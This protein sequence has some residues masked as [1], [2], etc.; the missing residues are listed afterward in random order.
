MKRKIISLV[1]AAV[2]ALTFC[3]CSGGAGTGETQESPNGIYWQA[4]VRTVIPSQSADNTTFYRYDAEKKTINVSTDKGFAEDKTT[5]SS[6]ETQD[7]RISKISGD[8]GRSEVTYSYSDGVLT[9]TCS[10][11]VYDNMTVKSGE[12]YDKYGIRTKL[13]TTRISDDGEMTDGTNF[14]Y[15]YTAFDENGCPTEAKVT[16][17]LLGGGEGGEIQASWKWDENG[18][19]LEEVMAGTVGG[20]YSAFKTVHEYDRFGNRVH[21]ILYSDE[22]VYQ[23]TY[24]TYIPGL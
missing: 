12:D 13:Y 16:V 17:E 10:S 4:S 2:M 15:D 3:A 21:T 8:E 20:V 7:G 22:D 11:Y 5:V 14:I 24:F 6:Y 23:E 1:L 19:M 9:A 18:N